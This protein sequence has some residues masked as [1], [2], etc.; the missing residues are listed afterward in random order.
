M[1]KIA[2]AKDLSEFEV[3]SGR[4]GFLTERKA[5]KSCGGRGTIFLQ[6]QIVQ[7]PT[8]IPADEYYAEQVALGNEVTAFSIALVL[9][10]NPHNYQVLIDRGFLSGDEGDFAAW[11]IVMKH[12]DEGALISSLR[13]S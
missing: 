2:T 6:T 13:G 3:R 1:N 9:I 12:I 5:F 7:N 11:G 4:S 10:G 8:T